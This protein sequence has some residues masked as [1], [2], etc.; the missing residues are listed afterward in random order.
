M[1]FGYSPCQVFFCCILIKKFY[2]KYKLN[3]MKNNKNKHF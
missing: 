1:G 2:I 3:G